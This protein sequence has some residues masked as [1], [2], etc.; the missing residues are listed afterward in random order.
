M[1]LYKDVPRFLYIKKPKISSSSVKYTFMFDFPVS[2]FLGIKKITKSRGEYSAQ[3]CWQ[4]HFL[5]SKSTTCHFYYVE[6]VVKLNWIFFLS[7]K[8]LNRNYFLILEYF[9]SIRYY[10]NYVVLYYY[11]CS[12]RI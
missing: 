6:C 10:S 5:T 8:F 12:F 2:L 9:N 7:K 4:V 3:L 11:I 1:F